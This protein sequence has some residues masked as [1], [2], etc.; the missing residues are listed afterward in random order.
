MSAD[1]TDAVCANGWTV[2]SLFFVS[3]AITAALNTLSITGILGGKGIPSSLGQSHYSLWLVC[4]SSSRVPVLGSKAVGHS[5]MAWWGQILNNSSCNVG[6]S[7]FLMSVHFFAVS[8]QIS[9]MVSQCL[10][11]WVLC[12]KCADCIEIR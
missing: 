11:F 4:L 12:S 1:C 6:S 10:V 2:V 9:S 5:A 8:F 7:V 3:Q